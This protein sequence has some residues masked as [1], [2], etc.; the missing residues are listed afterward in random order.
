MSPT[1]PTAPTLNDTNAY[2]NEIKSAI[3]DIIVAY[4]MH[5]EA[6]SRMEVAISPSDVEDAR[7]LLNHATTYYEQANAKLNAVKSLILQSML[8]S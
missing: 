1:T 4:D 5:A 7:E 6:K 3:N 2:I 8:N